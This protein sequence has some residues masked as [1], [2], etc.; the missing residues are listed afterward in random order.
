MATSSFPGV[1]PLPGSKGCH[2]SGKLQENQQ[3][4]KIESR[5]NPASEKAGFVCELEQW[6]GINQPIA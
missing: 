5:T 4:A 1:L 3:S 6:A 2:D